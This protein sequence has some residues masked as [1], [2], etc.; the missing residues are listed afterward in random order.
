MAGAKKVAPLK[1]ATKKGEASQAAATPAAKKQKV[2]PEIKKTEKTEKEPQKKKTGKGGNVSKT[3]S[4]DESKDEE[5]APAKRVTEEEEPK[6]KA[7]QKRE[8]KEIDLEALTEEKEELD[9]ASEDIDEDDAM[10]ELDD[11]QLLELALKEEEDDEKAETKSTKRYKSLKSKKNVLYLGHVPHGFFEEEIK[12]FLS[13]F[14]KILNVRVSRSPKTGNS[15]GYAFVQVAHPAVADIV[16]KT[17][18][19]YMLLGRSLVCQLVPEEHVH[20]RL[21]WGGLTG[22]NS[23]V[24]TYKDVRKNRVLRHVPSDAAKSKSRRVARLNTADKKR[25]GK[26]AARGINYAF[27]GVAGVVTPVDIAQAKKRSAPSGEI[28]EES[29]AKKPKGSEKK[30]ETEVA[31]PVSG[32]KPVVNAKVAK[33]IVQKSA[34]SKQSKNDQAP[35]EVSAEPVLET[36]IVKPASKSAVKAKPTKATAVAP[37]EMV[38]LGEGKK[39]T[40]KKEEK[41]PAP[42]TRATR[43]S[44]KAVPAGVAKGK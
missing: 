21:F 28:T 14:G 31:K 15:R 26:I 34:T 4:K 20:D 29:A 33:T 41:A 7:L 40:P 35:A 5:A 16:K 32:S 11:E 30:N 12:G 9:A 44:A 39:P 36:T 23:V 18:H 17:M 25:A 38:P 10:L 6:S 2:T 19:G 3:P 27:K 8:Q 42:A 43:A 22:K 37:K 1:H 13:Q 24:E